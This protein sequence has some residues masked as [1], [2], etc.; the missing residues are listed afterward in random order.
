[1]GKGF[2]SYVKEFPSSPETPYSY[3]AVPFALMMKL[4]IVGVFSFLALLSVIIYR[5]LK[6]RTSEHLSVIVGGIIFL[7]VGG[8]TNP[9]IL[10]FI[11]MGIFSFFLLVLMNLEFDV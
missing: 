9:Y 4:G 3:E 10:N 11:G 6:I 1:L 7:F 2:G 5:S 8:M